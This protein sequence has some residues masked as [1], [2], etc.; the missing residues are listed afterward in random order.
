MFG[1]KEPSRP[2]SQEEYDEAVR[3]L[4]RQVTG[5]EPEDDYITVENDHYWV[6][7]RAVLESVG[8][9]P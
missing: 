3:A 5:K 1:R 4:M 2:V 7:A 8:L 9:K 6:L